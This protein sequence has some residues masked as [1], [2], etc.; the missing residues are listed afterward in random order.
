MG[1]REIC[2]ITGTSTQRTAS[3]PQSAPK[4][5]LIPRA[6]P[7]PS[8]RQEGGSGEYGTNFFSTLEFLR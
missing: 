7:R 6:D 3:D 1:N 2:V 5:G 8:V 4:D